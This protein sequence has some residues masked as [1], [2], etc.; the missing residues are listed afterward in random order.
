[1]LTPTAP[2]RLTV[3]R[4]LA[5][6]V[7]RNVSLLTLITAPRVLKLGSVGRF[8]LAPTTHKDA[9]PQPK[10]VSVTG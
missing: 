6:L 3:H 4:G 2:H 8:V 1:M 7:R 5:N 9:Q 10:A